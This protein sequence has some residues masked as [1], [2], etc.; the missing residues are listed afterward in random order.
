MKTTITGIAICFVMMGLLLTACPSQRYVCDNDKRER[1]IM[2]CL[3]RTSSKVVT[4]GEDV[5]LGSAV[6][7][8]KDMAKDLSCWYEKEK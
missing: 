1:L 7:H 4:A 5:D 2:E 3:D 6:W 8:C